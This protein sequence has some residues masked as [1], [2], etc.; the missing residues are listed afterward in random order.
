VIAYGRSEERAT[1]YAREM[2]DM[3]DVVVTPA[4]TVERA[5]R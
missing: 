3:H 1:A 4:K 2:D 5:V